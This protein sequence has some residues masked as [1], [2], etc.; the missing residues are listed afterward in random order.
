MDHSARLVLALA[1]GAACL[2]VMQGASGSHR[3]CTD[4]GSDATILVEPPGSTLVGAVP[5]CVSVVSGGTLTFRVLGPGQHQI[6]SRGDAG[7]CWRAT[8]ELGDAFVRRLAFDGVHM[9][10]LAPGPEADCDP[11]VSWESTASE[12]I[13][14]F[15]CRL[16]RGFSGSIVIRSG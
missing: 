4:G 10:R 13:V 11:A 16:H 3:A 7:E 2:A 6:A 15:E 8:R 14:P 1:I 12:A 9:T 5:S